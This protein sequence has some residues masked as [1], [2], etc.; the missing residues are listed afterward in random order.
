MH[1]GA[2]FRRNPY[3]WMETP[4]LGEVDFVWNYVGVTKPRSGYYDI[5]IYD[6]V[7]TAGAYGA[8][9]TGAPSPKY[10]SGA[11]FAPVGGLVNIY[12]IVTNSGNYGRRWGYPRRRIQLG[13]GK[14]IGRVRQA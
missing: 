11:D 12:D 14:P 9:A 7:M 4:P 3:Y 8:T 13:S 10:I 6:V 2:T 5:D 1:A